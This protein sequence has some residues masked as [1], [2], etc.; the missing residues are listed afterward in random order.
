MGNLGIFQKIIQ[1][2]I[3]NCRD[4]P[5]TEKYSNSAMPKCRDEHRKG[6]FPQGSFMDGWMDS[7]IG[8]SSYK[9]LQ[10]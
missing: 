9:P 4:T 1:F 5:K 2:C 7:H 10:G 6:V 8:N 3:Q